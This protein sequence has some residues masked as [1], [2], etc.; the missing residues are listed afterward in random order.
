M[1]YLFL[2]VA[3]F[4]LSSFIP[5]EE[6]GIPAV[7][8][9]SLDGKSVNTSDITND[10]K[11][12]ILCIWEMSCAPCIHEFDEISKKYENWQKETGVKIV[13]I[14]VDDNRNYNRVPSLVK[15]KG[16]KFDFYQDK[17][18]DLKRALGV[19]ICPSTIIINGKGEIVW[20]KSGYLQGDEEIIYETLQKVTKGEKVS[21]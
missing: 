17:N 20:R 13:A 7:S 6:N 21:N 16:W 10:K 8:V 2:F 5:N 14:S 18:Q 11:P 4:S 1:R 19:S 3:L 9:K 12:I 15:S